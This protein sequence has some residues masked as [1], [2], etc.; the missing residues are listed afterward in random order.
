M[1]LAQCRG[2]FKSIKVLEDIVIK[3]IWS[4][5]FYCCQLIDKPD[6]KTNIMIEYFIFQIILLPNAEAEFN[7]AIASPSR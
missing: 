7:T 4:W 2:C 6:I 5:L 3:E 1:D